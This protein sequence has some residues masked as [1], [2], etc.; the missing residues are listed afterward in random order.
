MTRGQVRIRRCGFSRSSISATA[1]AVIADRWS[2]GEGRRLIDLAADDADGADE[3]DPVWVVPGFVGGPA[4]QLPDRVVSQQDSP[5]LLLDEF[6]GLGAED[7]AGC[8]QVR[9]DLVQ[10]GFVLP[11]LV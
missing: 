5:H 9:L 1:A 2:G 6:G 10:P 3:A 7:R 4:H 11:P 8:A